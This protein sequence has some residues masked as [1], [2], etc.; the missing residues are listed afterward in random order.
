MSRQECGT[1]VSG[2]SVYSFKSLVRVAGERVREDGMSD[3]LGK[4]RI[5][6]KGRRR[7]IKISESGVERKTHKG[8]LRSASSFGVWG[9]LSIS[10]IKLDNEGNSVSRSDFRLP[11]NIS[12]INKES[13]FNQREKQEEIKLLTQEINSAEKVDPETFDA[14]DVLLA[15]RQL[16]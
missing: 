12:L 10:S 16:R 9:G 14:L 7:V 6:L 13:L 11:R 4:R 2:E 1:R 15:R 5:V 3:H 8:D